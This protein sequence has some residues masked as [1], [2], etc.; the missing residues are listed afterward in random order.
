MATEG[1]APKIPA[2]V[3]GRKSW[4]TA[5]KSETIRP[6]SANR[7]ASSAILYPCRPRPRTAVRRGY[8]PPFRDGELSERD[9]EVDALALAGQLQRDGALGHGLRA[10]GGAHSRVG[11]RS[12]VRAVD[13][14]DVA[15]A[16]ESAVAIRDLRFADREASPLGANADV[17]R[18]AVLAGDCPAAARGLVEGR[19]AGEAELH[20]ARG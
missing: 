15:H 17:R 8:S 1:A 11:F 5:A 14:A 20:R 18:L 9:A 19:P 4:P 16:R 7:S 13:V 3:F 6:P 10:R 12:A 2:K